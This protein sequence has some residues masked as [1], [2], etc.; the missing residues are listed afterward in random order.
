MAS[1]SIST[2]VKTQFSLR[3]RLSLKVLA[4]NLHSYVKATFGF[5]YQRNWVLVPG[6]LFYLEQWHGMPPQRAGA[7]TLCCWHWISLVW[8][9]SADT[10]PAL[11][12][13]YC[14]CIQR[15][16]HVCWPP[17]PWTCPLICTEYPTLTQRPERLAW[18]STS[19]F[20]LVRWHQEVSG[21]WPLYFKHGGSFSFTDAPR[22]HQL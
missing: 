2:Y 3:L 9:H 14:S 18:K 11:Y 22:S 20:L 19:T 17:L 21:V 10:C 15:S 12:Q 5:L 4:F 8:N 16:I 1:F 6:L 7:E 13:W